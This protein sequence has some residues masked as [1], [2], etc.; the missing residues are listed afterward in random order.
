MNI[1]DIKVFERVYQLFKNCPDPHL[2]RSGESWSVKEILGHLVDSVSNNYQRI[3]RYIPGGELEFPGYDQEECVRRAD[4][5]SFDF[6]RLM[7]LWYNHNKLLFHLYD[8]IPLKDLVSKI[9]VGEN[10]AMTIEALMVDYFAHMR[11]HERQVREIIESSFC[12]D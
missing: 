7:A 10:P 5:S 6:N 11:A 4:Y 8:R 2:K 3:Q 1:E 9:K 12:G